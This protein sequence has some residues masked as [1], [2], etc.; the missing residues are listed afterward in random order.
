MTDRISIKGTVEIQIPT[1]CRLPAA[2]WNTLRPVGIER[3]VDM[4]DRE[5]GSRIIRIHYDGVDFAR[6]V[7]PVMI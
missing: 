2:L 3:T 5:D 1:G 4:I 7:E 6:N